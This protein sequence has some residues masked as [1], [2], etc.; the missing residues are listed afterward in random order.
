MHEL[1]IADAVASMILE[2]AETRRVARVGMRI[3]HLRQV[4]PASLRFSF[5]LVTHDTCAAGADL[6][7]ET[8]PAAVWCDECGVESAPTSFPL[9]CDRCGTASV[10]V[11]RGDELSVEWIEMEE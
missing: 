2:R 5:A 7:I 4:V 9:R 6:E 11:R 10:I 3:G 8:V 1:A